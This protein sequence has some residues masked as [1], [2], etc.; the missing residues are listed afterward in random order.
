M[1]TAFLFHGVGGSPEEN[2]FPWM[3]AKL[4][5]KGITVIIPQ[6]PNP[7]QPQFSEWLEHFAQYRDEMNEDTVF[8]GHSLGAAFTLRFLEKSDVRIDSAFL[9]APVWSVMGNEYDPLMTSFTVAPYDWNRIRKRCEKFAVIQSDNDPYITV[10]KSEVLAEN[11]GAEVTLIPG[12]GHFNSRAGYT[13]FP[14][15]LEE[16]EKTLSNN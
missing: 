13:E 9:V 2:W 4:E 16:I 8:I 6:F 14:Q 11:L 10:E 5:E 15:L 1:A 12:G 7:D 3:K